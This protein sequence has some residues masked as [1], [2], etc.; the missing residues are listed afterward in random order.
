M[1]EEDPE[2]TRGLQVAKTVGFT[3][4]NPGETADLGN[5][6]KLQIE[7]HNKETFKLPTGPRDSTFPLIQQE[8]VDR[9]MRL[10][11]A[12]GES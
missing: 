2:D 5:Y 7:K 10:K 8:H 6:V 1:A 12:Q 3:K 9:K 11:H 4:G